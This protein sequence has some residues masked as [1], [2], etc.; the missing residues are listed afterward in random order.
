METEFFKAENVTSVP[1]ETRSGEKRFS[2]AI[3]DVFLPKQD[4][5]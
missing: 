5:V 3:R 2:W 1:N 4:L